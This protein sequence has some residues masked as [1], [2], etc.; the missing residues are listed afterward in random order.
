[1]LWHHS[2]H[3]LYRLDSITWSYPKNAI[4]LYLC[5][6]VSQQPC[7]RQHLIYFC[8]CECWKNILARHVNGK[9][10]QVGSKK[11]NSPITLQEWCLVGERAWRPCWALS[12]KSNGKRMNKELQT[13]LQHLTWKETSTEAWRGT[14]L[15][16]RV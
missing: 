13:A 7:L 14:S 3:T 11:R 16:G 5:V 4:S 10:Q 6:P 12:W 8:L 15:E 9:E 1:M 2:L